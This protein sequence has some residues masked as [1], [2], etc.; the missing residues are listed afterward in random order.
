MKYNIILHEREEVF[1]VSYGLFSYNREKKAGENMRIGIIGGG[2]SGMAAALAAAENPEVSVLLFERQARLGRKLLATGN[3][4]CNLTNMHCLEDG[5]HGQEAEF[6]RPALSEFGPEETLEWF[7]GMG[8][9]TVA[10]SSG[11]VYP[12]SDQANS[13]VD[14]LRFALERPNI[15]VLTGCEVTKVKHHSG[16][17]TVTTDTQTYTC[18]KLIVACGGLA[19]SK[20]GGSM[21]GY[22][23]LG[24]LGH[25]TTRLRPA[26]VQLKSDWGGIAALKGV[27]ANCQAAI[28]CGEQLHAQSSGEIQFTEYG[29]SGPVIFEISRDACQEK[30]DWRCVLDLLP[31]LSQETLLEELCRRRAT[32][33]PAEELLTGILHNRLGRVLTK[34]AGVKGS[35]PIRELSEETLS[36]VCRA[37]KAFELPLTEP[38][39]MDHAQVT[40]GGVLTRDFDPRTMES[41][42]LPGL[43][44]CGEVLDIDGDCGGYNLQWAWSSGRAAGKHAGKETI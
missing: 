16:I 39:G 35:D 4:R 22:K 43:Y 42:L 24:K 32:D 33:L 21:S 44:A 30:G 13:V 14:V 20:L 15:R 40:A 38:L 36:Q 6:A 1:L 37:V 26:L 25:R 18:Q 31:Q 19:G 2:A 3:G 29:L 11:R 12:Y 10:E 7:R 28:Y 9:L 8:L 34:A 27:R 41:L 23:L 5:Y 17:F